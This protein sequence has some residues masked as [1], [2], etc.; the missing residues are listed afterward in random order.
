MF[1]LNEVRLLAHYPL[2]IVID[3]KHT[4][5]EINNFS[6]TCMHATRAIG[7]EILWWFLASNSLVILSLIA[8]KNRVWPS[9]GT[10]GGCSPICPEAR[11][12]ASC[13]PWLN[14]QHTTA[15]KLFD[16][17]ATYTG[18]NCSRLE[19]CIDGFSYFLLGVVPEILGGW[20]VSRWLKQHKVSPNP[21][22]VYIL[23]VEH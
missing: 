20:A 22:K 11:G 4:K 9:R 13:R 17:I 1:V 15:V 3:V 23:G 5:C 8:I 10:G 6:V 14:P 2:I 7:T 16:I 12:C 21:S 19:D 18:T